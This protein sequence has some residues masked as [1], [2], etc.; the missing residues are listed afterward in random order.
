M[1]CRKSSVG[2]ASFLLSDG[3]T[4]E[5]DLPGGR[6]TTFASMIASY[7]G[8]RTNVN[9]RSLGPWRDGWKEGM[10]VAGVEPDAEGR[11][12]RNVGRDGEP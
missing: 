7:T 9:P 4:E 1:V 2:Q 10:V 3:Q 11:K 12:G 8:G 5:V 6:P